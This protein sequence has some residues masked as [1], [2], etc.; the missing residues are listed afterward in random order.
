MLEVLCIIYGAAACEQYCVHRCCC[1]PT[2]FAVQF[3]RRYAKQILGPPGCKLF[4]AV[5]VY[6]VLSS[7]G[8]KGVPLV[9]HV[10]YRHADGATTHSSCLLFVMAVPLYIG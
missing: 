5:P 4:K 8:T 3:A 6:G 7:I 10:Y 2:G 1:D 9:L